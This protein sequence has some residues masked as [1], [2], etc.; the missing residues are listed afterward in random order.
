[1]GQIHTFRSL[2]NT[3]T[4]GEQQIPEPIDEVANIQ[5]ITYDRKIKSSMKRTTKKRKLMLDNLILI[6]TEKN[7]LSIEHA[8]TSKLIGAERAIMDATLDRERTDEKELSIALKDFEHLRHLVKYYQ[9]STEAQ[10][11]P[12]VSFKM[13][14]TNS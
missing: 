4:W 11:F 14:M 7:F 1:M 5:V 2:G 3:L 10:F 9:D 13:A 8:K 12:E 6:T